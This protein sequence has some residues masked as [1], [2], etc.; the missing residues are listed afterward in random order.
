MHEAKSF[1]E[2]T[3]DD[4]KKQLNEDNE[5]IR[6]SMQIVEK[7]DEMITEAQEKSAQMLQEGEAEAAQIMEEAYMLQEKANE[8]L[9]EAEAQAEMVAQEAQNAVESIIAEANMES[10]R[11]I[12]AAEQSHQE[13][14]EAATQD[15]FNVGYQ[16]GRE[17]A[18]KE[19]AQLLMETTN[20]LN[21]LHSAFPLAIRQN[22]DKLIKL[23]MSVARD[24]LN[25]ELEVKPE[26]VLTNV[27][28]AINKVSDIERVIIRVNPLDLDIV[29]P[30]LEFY[31]GILPDVQEFVITGHY[32][33]ERGGCH[34]ETNSGTIDSQPKAQ[35]GV[36]EEV[37]MRIRSEYDYTDEEESTEEEEEG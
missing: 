22:E 2:K 23:S 36:V 21:K 8:A 29:L 26:L 19:N 7:S 27:E 6:A 16:E 25:N 5:M 33:I 14:V 10:A 30:R 17:E 13:I 37:F 35:L 1:I 4:Y 31:R 15:G 28:R 12:E 20:A 18:I 9:M 24:I 34:I 3:I 32:S 11:I